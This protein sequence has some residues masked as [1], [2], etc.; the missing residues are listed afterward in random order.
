MGADAG[1]YKKTRNTE[2]V[3]KVKEKSKLQEWQ[4]EVNVLNDAKL[5]ISMQ[6]IVK[7]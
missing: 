3:G 2:K 1:G 4:Y 5:L 6:K 7:E